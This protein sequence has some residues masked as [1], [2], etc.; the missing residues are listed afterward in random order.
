M[1]VEIT[2]NSKTVNKVCTLVVDDDVR[3]LRFISVNLRL[4]GYDVIT[5]TN[6]EEAIKLAE[7]ERVKIMLLDMLMSVMDGFEN[8]RNSL[9]INLR[10]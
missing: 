4:N 6:G 5:T 8:G 1:S 10:S 3:I 7:S 2:S 9:R